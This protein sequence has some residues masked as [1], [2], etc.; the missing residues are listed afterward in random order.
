MSILSPKN[1]CL[2]RILRSSAACKNSL[3]SLQ[4]FD[5][6]LK[7]RSYTSTTGSSKGQ[8]IS[9]PTPIDLKPHH[10]G[11][12]NKSSKLDLSFEDSKTAFKAKSNLDLLRGYLVFQLCSIKFLVDNQKRILDL[13]RKVFGKH[14]FS[15]IMKSTFYGHFVAGQDQQD[16]RKN[17]ENMMKYGVKSILD[18]SAEEDLNSANKKND[19]VKLLG[20]ESKYFDPSEAQSDKN[21]RIFLDCIDAVSGKYFGKKLTNLIPITLKS[22][23]RRDTCNW[24]CSS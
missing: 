1:M 6:S 11:V 7:Q 19:E 4:L 18:Y 13:T 3:A 21:K 16:I 2:M 12:S 17:V 14:L 9:M 15:I 5:S 23:V 22:F 8:A 20:G 10:D 24:Y